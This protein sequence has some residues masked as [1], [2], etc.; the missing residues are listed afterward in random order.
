M[1]PDWAFLKFLVI[2]FH[3]KVAQMNGDCLGHFVKTSRLRKTALATFRVTFGKKL[4]N[5]LYR[6][7]VTLIWS[8]QDT[9]LII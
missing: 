6:H 1:G 8:A 7:L 5:F 4:D 9:F 2:N 3:T